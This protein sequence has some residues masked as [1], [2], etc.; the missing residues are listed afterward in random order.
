V[1]EHE[2]QQRAL[3]GTCFASKYNSAA[4]AGQRVGQ[5][6]V[7]ELTLGPPSAKP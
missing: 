2:A 3:A 5:D 7:E 6:R 1:P 4:P